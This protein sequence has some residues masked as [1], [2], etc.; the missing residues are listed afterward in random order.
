MQVKQF[1]SQLGYVEKD[2]KEYPNGEFYIKGGFPGRKIYKQGFVLSSR[3]TQT[4]SEQSKMNSQTSTAG[5][6]ELTTK[7]MKDEEPTK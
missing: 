2:W 4:A 6:E 1:K 3:N 7:S 5:Q